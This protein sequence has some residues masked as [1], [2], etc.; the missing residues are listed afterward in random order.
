MNFL[1][2]LFLYIWWHYTTAIKDG[3][4]IWKKFVWFV[5]N[6]FSVPL[7]TR[8]FFYRFER[9]GENYKKGFSITDNLSAFVVN[10]MMRLV[11]MTLRSIIII[12]GLVATFLACVFGV[13]VLILWIIYPLLFVT[14]IIIGIAKII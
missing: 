12:V 6:F 3:F 11:G 1:S 8:T 14:A 7:L 4:E 13:I 5:F 2:V 10:T 9:L